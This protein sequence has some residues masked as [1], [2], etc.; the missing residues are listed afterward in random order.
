[1]RDIQH[2]QISQSTD[3][4][5]A[6]RLDDLHR[7]AI[8]WHGM[9]LFMPRELREYQGILSEQFCRATGRRSEPWVRHCSLSYLES[10]G[11][12]QS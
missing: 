1:M 12:T 11:I 4:E 10:K 3:A 2:E 7:G 8:Q 5:L 9:R 6:A